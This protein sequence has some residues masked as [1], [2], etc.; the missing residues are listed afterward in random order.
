[1][2]SGF[3]RSSAIARLLRWRFWKSGSWRAEKSDGPAPSLPPSSRASILMTL[4][5]QSANWRTQV[6]PDRTRV[7]SRTTRSLS[8]DEAGRKDIPLS[9]DL[10][11]TRFDRA[12][13]VRDHL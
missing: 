1:M 13:E 8:A 2:P 6:G 9:D 10:L 7:R 12:D 4:A 11:A 3:L 5:P